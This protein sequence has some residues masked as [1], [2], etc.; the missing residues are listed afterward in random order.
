METG[1][2]F[3]R[4]SNIEAYGAQKASNNH[5]DF[6]SAQFDLL[7]RP[8]DCTD[9]LSSRVKYASTACRQAG[10]GSATAVE[11]RNKVGAMFQIQVP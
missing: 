2:H 10:Q 11:V 3:V 9:A 7:I 1:T 4:P 8:L 5:F 6:E